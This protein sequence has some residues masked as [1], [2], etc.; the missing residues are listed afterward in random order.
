MSILFCGGEDIDFMDVAAA[1]IDTTSGICRTAYV[2]HGV[3]SSSGFTRSNPFSGGAVTSCWLSAQWGHN[4]A[5]NGGRAFGLVSTQTG[6]NRGLWIGMDNANPAKVTLSKYDGTTFTVLGTSSSGYY[7]GN[8]V[9]LHKI[10][11]QVINYGATATV[12]VYVDGASV[13]SYTGDVTVS[14]ITSLNCVGLN[15]LF[16]NQQGV[17]EIIVADVDT[18]GL[19]LM[20]MAPTGAGTTDAWTGAYTDVN[21]AT[22]SDATALNTNTASQDEQF[23]ITDLLAGSFAI[24]AVRVA[25]RTALAGG[26]TPVGIQ[27]G[28][29]SGGSVAVGATKTPA[30]TYGLVDQIFATNPVTSAA[31]VQSDMNALQM[32]LRSV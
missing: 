24:Q 10:D 19:S 12:N 9:L 2:R 21:E 16:G 7:T 4:S 15:A 30:T 32:N 6:T 29:N 17:S 3:R 26:S 18:R 31:W 8:T 14:G 25:A 13:I 28:F 11:M 5:S 27:L 20:T 1:V 23:N 22:T